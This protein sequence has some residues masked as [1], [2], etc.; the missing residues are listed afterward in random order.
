MH[1][2]GDELKQSCM[3]VSFSEE[4]IANKLVPDGK[5]SLVNHVTANM[6]G[7]P[8]REQNQDRVHACSCT[9]SWLVVFAH[10]SAWCRTRTRMESH[11][12]TRIRS[13]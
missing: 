9:R 2:R 3:Y 13:T 6:N 1:V 8:I 11:S 7:V 4:H 12:S 5:Y 10:R